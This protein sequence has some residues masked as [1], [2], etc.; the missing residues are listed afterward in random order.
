M[1]EMEDHIGRI[2][3]K[4]DEKFVICLRNLSSRI[5]EGGVDPGSSL[6]LNTDLPGD[7]DR[8]DFVYEVDTAS[9]ETDLVQMVINIRVIIFC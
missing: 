2:L 8:C 4:G 9:M 5:Q 3:R 1:G 6:T 7:L